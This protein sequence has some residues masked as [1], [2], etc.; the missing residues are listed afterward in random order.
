MTIRVLHKVCSVAMVFVVLFSTLSFTIESHYC[1]NNLID[2][3]IFSKVK[4]C[5][6]EVQ[7]T[8]L[9]KKSCCKSEV[10]VIKGQNKLKIDDYFKVNLNF[11]YQ[12]IALP[13]SCLL[14]Y[15]S[16]PKHTI[17]NRYYLPP[18]LVY[19]VQILDQIFLI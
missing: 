13:I 10:E 3:A 15:A 16:L 5:S 8:N 19:N 4:D 14:L 6:G 9:N 17:P 11:K 18:K 2:T 12:A 1:G 7:S